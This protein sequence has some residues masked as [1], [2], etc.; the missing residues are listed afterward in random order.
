MRTAWLTLAVSFVVLGV[1]RTVSSAFAIL[2]LPLQDELEASRAAVTLIFTAHML[3][4]A[5]ASLL[6]GLLIG[7]FGPRATIAFGGILVFS[8]MASMAVGHSLGAL[9]LAYGVLCGAGVAFLG[10]PANFM[11]V[12]ERFPT[13]VATAMGIAAAGMGVGV[14]ALIPAIQWGTERFGWRETFVFSGVAALIIV[15]LCVTYRPVRIA[16]I[17]NADAPSVSSSAERRSMGNDMLDLL[18]SGKWQTFAAANFL[19]GSA[20]FG[21]LTHQVTLLRESGWTAIAAATSLGLLNL[22]RSVSG[23]LWGVLV[24]RSGH[25][26]GYGMSTAIAVAGIASIGSLH[27]GAYPDTR[28]YLFVIAFGIGTAG[29]LPMNASLSSDLFKREQRPIAWGSA[30][31]AYAAGAAFGSWIVAFLFDHSGNYVPALALTGLELLASYGFVI[32]LSAPRQGCR[33]AQT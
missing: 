33:A 14:L 28:V 25:R 13:R 7:R 24:D 17:S 18:R 16:E 19:I 4:Y 29:T 30:E 26:V 22:F 2:V 10:V 6:C 31:T 8:G 15:A 21:I 9:A 5:A 12:S 11:L 3:V 32:A 27:V 23:P 1:Y 20:L